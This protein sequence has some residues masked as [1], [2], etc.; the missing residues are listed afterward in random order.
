MLN[1]FINLKKNHLYQKK[2][3]PLNTHNPHLQIAHLLVNI[4]HTLA[5]PPKSTQNRT[6]TKIQTFANPPKSTQNPKTKTKT[7]NPRKKN[8]NHETPKSQNKTLK[9]PDSKKVYQTS[10]CNERERDTWAPVC[11]DWGERESSFPCAS[12]S[13]SDGMRRVICVRVQKCRVRMVGAKI[14]SQAVT[15]LPFYI[16]RG[17][18]SSELGL[19]SAK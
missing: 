10:L 17:W 15:L 12:K 13:P 7:K 3:S 18:G 11:G 8:P 1:P 19:Q 2:R 16:I 14:L 9:H 6:F 5:K 4:R